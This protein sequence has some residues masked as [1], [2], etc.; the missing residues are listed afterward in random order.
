MHTA[1]INLDR[2]RVAFGTLF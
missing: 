2:S 1:M